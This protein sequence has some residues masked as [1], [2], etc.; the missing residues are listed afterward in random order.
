[1]KYFGLILGQTALILS[2]TL[3][4]RIKFKLTSLPRE[5][6]AL[7]RGLRSTL[8]TA[9]LIV[10]LVATLHICIFVAHK[11][12]L[13]YFGVTFS[14]RVWQHVD[15]ATLELS[16]RSWPLST[17]LA[18]LTVLSVPALYLALT[19][20][21]ATPFRHQP[22]F[23]LIPAVVISFAGYILVYKNKPFIPSRLF[24]ETAS[25][26]LL[27]PEEQNSRGLTHDEKLFLSS[28]GVGA[29]GDGQIRFTALKP[30]PKA[31]NL[32][33]IYLEA[34]DVLYTNITSKGFPSL[35]PTINALAKESTLFRHW[36]PAGGWTIAAL[37]GSHCGTQLDPGSTNGNAYLVEKFSFLAPIMCFTDLLKDAGF[38]SVFMGGA[39]P[40]FSGKGD[41]LKSNGYDEVIGREWFENSNELKSKMQDWGLLDWEMFNQAADKAL[42]LHQKNQRFLFTFLTLNTHQPGFPQSS[43]CAPFP[44]EAKNEPLRRGA[45]CTDKALQNFLARLNAAGVWKDTALWLQSDHPQFETDLKR[46]TFGPEGVS[47]KELVSILKLPG[48]TKPSV[49]ETPAT[50]FDFPA[51]ALDV[52]GVGYTGRFQRGVSV[53]QEDFKKR[54][55]VVS[56]FGFHGSH[57]FV[58]AAR[59]SI[60]CSAFEKN[61]Q[62]PPAWSDCAYFTLTRLVSQDQQLHHVR[63]TSL[64]QALKDLRFELNPEGKT[65]IVY[66]ASDTS[67]RNLLLHLTEAEHAETQTEVRPYMLEFSHSGGILSTRKLQFN[68]E[69]QCQHKEALLGV[70]FENDHVFVR[71]CLGGRNLSQ[72]KVAQ[73]DTARLPL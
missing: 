20:K 61:H 68:Q 23:L 42:A 27:K 31:R 41:F 64:M 33:V 66:Q 14:A 46:S 69:L 37:F 53:F 29:I 9:R 54:T 11:L 26:S 2:L 21:L 52:L 15:P 12:L 48:N 57:E 71:N 22:P 62:L 45:V 7:R 60:D 19:R 58:P 18:L 32:V 10:A 65:P 30:N 1:M 36:Y 70:I 6:P 39:S 72:F 73:G 49:V 28:H 24:I 38:K 13:K 16:V 55:A 5:L 8:D 59:Q 34:F 35:T 63:P 51:S 17:L 56:A 25:A 4:S 67:R 43:S 3:L 50:A 40:R 47:N 44:A